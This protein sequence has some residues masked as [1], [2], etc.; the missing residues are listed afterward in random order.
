MSCPSDI[1]DQRCQIINQETVSDLPELD[2]V[3]EEAD[4]RLIPHTLHAVADGTKRVCL[5]T[6]DTDVLVIGLY[7]WNE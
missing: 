2:I 3:L 4:V 5:L 1:A 6:N 7:F